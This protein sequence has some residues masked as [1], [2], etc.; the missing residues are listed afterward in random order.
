MSTITDL[1]DD[2]DVDLLDAG[3]VS[4]FESA[5]LKAQRIED[6]Q[7]IKDCLD[8]EKAYDPYNHFGANA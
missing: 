6:R 5:R 7:Y 3:F 4:S 1:T 8:A 2:L